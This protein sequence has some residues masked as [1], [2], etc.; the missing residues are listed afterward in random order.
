MDVQKIKY[1]TYLFEGAACHWWAIIERRWERDEVKNSWER[2]KEEFL[3][4][5]IPQVI[6]DIRE[7]E[8]M[9]LIQGSLTVVQYEAEF[10]R[11][12]QYAPHVLA[13]EERRR[14][15]FIEGLKLELRKAVAINRPR[16]YDSAVETAMELEAEFQEIHRFGDKKKGK[17]TSKSDS[18]KGNKDYFNK[19]PKAGSTSVLADKGKTPTNYRKESVGTIVV[20]TTLKTSVGRS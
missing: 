19:K 12:I 6:R 16:D 5:Y 2:F 7:K 20:R 4:K 3:R 17:W 11:L 18:D 1:A 10:N 8:F 15:K 9:R 14:K 13:D